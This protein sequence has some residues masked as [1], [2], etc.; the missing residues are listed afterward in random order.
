MAHIFE[1]T[2]TGDRPARIEPRPANHESN[3][4]NKEVR[5][6]PPRVNFTKALLEN[7][8]LKQPRRSFDFLISLAA[9]TAFVILLMLLPLLYMHAMTVPDFEKTMLILPP[10]P[11]PSP[12]TT[13]HA[14][15]K[16]KIRL[17]E[18]DK[19]YA[20]RT[21]PKHVAMLKEA[22]EETA[23]VSNVPGVPGGVPG[24]TLGG[25][26]GGVLGNGIAPASPPPPKAVASTRPL[27]VGG[28]IQPPRLIQKIQPAYP[29][30]AKE[31]RTHGVVV[32]DCVIDK[33]G[34]VTQMK[35]V[36]GNPFLV[37]AAMN[38]VQQWK[39]QPT[40]LNG[41]PIAVEMEVNVDFVI[42]S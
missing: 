28:K 23:G 7:S 11:P 41:Q 29:V 14:M 26:L 42:G 38:A 10:P 36:S 1:K 33:Q 21:I 20:P 6:G 35:V 19:L 17:F 18:N 31:T 22:P 34:N 15:V 3:E 13:M 25:V 12:A 39:Y 32:L 4:L 5:G 27:R 37:Q 16:P 8:D 24:G 40:L 2:E 30:L 9:Q